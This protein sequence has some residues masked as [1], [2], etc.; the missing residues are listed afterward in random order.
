M[1]A[2]QFRG[3]LYYRL[4]VL[5]LQVPPLRER[6]EDI[7]ALVEFLLDDI[8]NRS[9]QAPMELSHKAVSYTHLDVYKRQGPLRGRGPDKTVRDPGNDLRFS[10]PLTPTH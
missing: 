10:P 4:N 6:R 8:A 3:D 1:A 7:P 5:A 9:G 2:G